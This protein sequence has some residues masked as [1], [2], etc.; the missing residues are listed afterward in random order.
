MVP[1]SKPQI[2]WS[3]FT[4]RPR[5]QSVQRYAV[6]ERVVSGGA[7]TLVNTEFDSYC[8]GEELAEDEIIRVVQ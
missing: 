8:A 5:T 6:K 1:K 3:P 7:R 4:D 2:T